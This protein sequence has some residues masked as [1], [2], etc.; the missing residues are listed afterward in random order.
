MAITEHDKDIVERT[1]KALKA[2]YLEDFKIPLTEDVISV[3]LAE[4]L[5][6]RKREWVRARLGLFKI[7][8]LVYAQ[9]L[10]PALVRPVIPELTTT[11]SVDGERKVSTKK[12]TNPQSD[13]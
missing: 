6:V 3:I 13:K 2:T 1:L 12:K 10:V 9:S 5:E 8:Q 7:P 11:K 4:C